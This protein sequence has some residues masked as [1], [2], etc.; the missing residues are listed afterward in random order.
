MTVPAILGT[1][2]LGN[3]RLGYESAQLR[4]IREARVR[5]LLAGTNV[6][7]RVNG[8]SIRDVLNETPNTATLTIDSPAPSSGQDLQIWLN[9]D[10][11]RLLFGGSLQTDDLTYE[12]KTTQLAYPA[13]GIDDTARLNKKRPFGTWTNISATTVVQEMVTS[14]APGFTTAHVEAAMPTITI[15]FDGSEDF[16]TC[17]GRIASAIG[18]YFK[19]EQLD[20]WLFLTDPS[21]EPPENL[22]D[23][24]P[25][26]LLDPPV[27]A[28]RDDSNL[29]TRVYGKGHSEATLVDL[30][31]GETVIPVEDAVMYNPGG[32]Q[33]IVATT[34]DGAASEILNY[35]GVVAGGAGTIVGPGAGPS[36]TPSPVAAA[37]SGLGTGVYQYGY[38]FVTAAGESLPSPVGSVTTGATVPNPTAVLSG[39]FSNAGG[40]PYPFSTGDAIRYWAYTVTTAAGET[41]PSPLFAPAIP[42][43]IGGGG[44]FV[45]NLVVPLG[46]P[47]ATG[48][49]IY[50][51]VAA[52]SQLKLVG[53]IADNTTTSYT[54]HTTD[55]SLGANVPTSSTAGTLNAVAINGI[56]IG[57]ASVTSRK[58]YRT[59]VGGAQLK[60][61]Q[62]IANN[63]AT[64]G[65]TDTTADGSLGANAPSSDAS[66][67]TQPF[68]QV[69]AGS[70]TIPIAGIGGLPTSGWL[71]TFGD[72]VRYTG[73]SGNSL[74]GIPATGTGAILTSLFYG[75]QVTPVPSLTGV[76]GLTK[77]VQRGSPVH[78]WVQRDDFAAQTAAAIRESTATYTS[79]GIHEYTITD[80]RRGED[81]L[82]ALCDA[83]LALFS[84]PIITVSYATRDPKTK[85]GKTITINLTNPP[86]TEA[87]TIQDVTISEIDV[88]PGL[89]PRF[90]VTASTVRQSLE[91]VLRRLITEQAA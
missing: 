46:S 55:A 15:T 1:A 45:A 3:F 57:P 87:L 72:V 13:T 43:P 25:L 38:T 51:T 30:V 85:S 64:S 54:D 66:G 89:Q 37:G 21:G 75:D 88:S 49:K 18:G 27:V 61:Q 32:G 29:M 63:T 20:V 41:L 28:N 22:V 36:V 65:G 5:I 58:V 67:L 8:L 84:R 16:A 26:L 17:L 60:L 77:D 69:N 10:A 68:G 74:T 91:D 71:F 31:A 23:G 33:V 81:S 53:T 12:G 2:R 80:E 90:M 14:F 76:T 19:I 35:T 86:I 7:V 4:T 42:Y 50:R 6:R 39:S 24:S 70:T 34:P 73:V 59:V 40:G 47:G 78:L 79:D 11:P 9:S 62:T 82:I 48:R 44:P 83:H 56:A 52:G